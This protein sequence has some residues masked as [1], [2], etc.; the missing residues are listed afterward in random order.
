M[1]NVAFFI[2]MP[3]VVVLSVVKL[4]VVLNKHG[5]LLRIFFEYTSI[6]NFKDFAPIVWTY[7]LFTTIKFCRVI[8]S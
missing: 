3:S 6:K 4:S 2:V 5:N 8:I 1:Q 7:K